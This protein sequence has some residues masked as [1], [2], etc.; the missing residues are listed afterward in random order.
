MKLHKV[1]LNFNRGIISKLG[2]ARQDIERLSLSAETLHNF[3]PRVLGSMILRAGLGYTGEGTDNDKKAIHIQFIKNIQDQATIEITDS[4]VRVKVDDSAILRTSVS[5][6]IVNSGF[7]TDIA[8]W[9]DASDVGSTPSWKSGGYLSL[10]GTGFGAAIVRQQVNVSG[11]DVGVAHAIRVIVSRGDLDISI[12]STVG[13][14]EYLNSLRLGEGSHSLSFTPTGNF[15]LQLSSK[16]KYATLIDSCSIE[17]TGNMSLPSPWLENDLKYIKYDQSEDVVYLSCKGYE[18][19]KIIRYGTTSWGLQKLLISD[20]PFRIINVDKTQLTPSAL[21]GDITLTASNSLFDVGHVGALFRIASYGQKV[22]ANIGGGGQFTDD[23][24]VTGIGTERLFNIDITGTWVGTVTLQKSFDEGGT[25]SDVTSY[26][27]NTSTTYND[28][29]D[30]Q[31][32]Y[33]RIGIKTGD[34]TS[35]SATTELS[36]DRGSINGIVRVVGVTSSTVADCIVLSDL[37]SLTSSENWYEGEWST[38]RGFPSANALHEGR[39]VFGGVGKVFFSV[40]DVYESF[41]ETGEGDSIAFTKTIPSGPTETVNWLLSLKRLLVGT[42]RDEWYVRSTS[43]DEALTS[44]NANMKTTSTLGSNYVQARKIDNVGVFVHSS[45]TRAYKS[46]YTIESD[47]FRTEDISKLIP[48]FLS[49]GVVRT[50]VQ[51][52]PDTRVHHI[53][54]DGTAVIYLHDEL[55]DIK[56]WW[57]LSTDGVIEDVF[58]SPSLDE[59]IVYYC[60]KRTI[61]GVDKRYLEKYAFEDECIGGTLSKQADSFITYSGAPTSTI[62]GLSHLEGENVI[63]WG[64]GKDLSPDDSNGVQ[65]TY[66]V[67]SGQ[68]ILS[69]SISEAVVGLP[70]TAQYKSVKLGFPTALGTSLLQEKN[71][72]SLGIVAINTH[73]KGIMYGPD[74]SILDDLPRMEDFDVVDSDTVYSDYDADMFEFDGDWGTD[75][76]ICLQAKAPRPANILAVV[77]GVEFHEIHDKR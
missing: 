44:A 41:D 31:I 19:Y 54:S 45:G 9:T 57:T 34:Y 69:E 77:A 71:I 30:N 10:V 18:S 26:T 13:G 17:S 12:G 66:T 65:Q 70:Y 20:G 32:I 48:E 24:K 67:T 3:T 73:N 55:E 50:A 11:G 8:S 16:T 53:L 74:F 42:E 59:D 23:I 47:D 49:I 46:G 68:I 72:Y 27:V 56:S 40:S 52:V 5:S 39:L 64:D 36:Y 28:G 29:S 60:V 21:T 38:Y 37:G 4:V 22:T 6:S 61:N 51:R 62:S 15:Y 33:Y 76:R 7:D 35:G 14:G 43:F 58:V 75:S 2:F 63:V 1:I 25:W